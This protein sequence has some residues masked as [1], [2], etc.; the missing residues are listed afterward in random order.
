MISFF[1]SNSS[2]YADISSLTVFHDFITSESFTSIKWSSKLHL[3][4]CPRNL[5]PN[6]LPSWAPSIRPG[7]SAI[8]SS[9]VLY[10]AIPRTGFKVVNG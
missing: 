6:P 7:I 1:K 4:I 9:L 8:T 10:L 2:E 3:S 5:S